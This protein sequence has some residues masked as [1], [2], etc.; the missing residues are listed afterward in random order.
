V[1]YSGGLAPTI[2]LTKLVLTD[3]VKKGMIWFF[4]RDNHTAH[5]GID[6]SIDFRV[7]NVIE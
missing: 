7:Y 4:S 5:N 3:E 2:P 6:F 1:S